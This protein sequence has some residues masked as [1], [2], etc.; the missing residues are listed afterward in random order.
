MNR[1]R[2]L[3]LQRVS[4]IGG[5]SA[6]ESIPQNTRF[7]KS[8]SGAFTTLTIEAALGA[9]MAKDDDA[10]NVRRQDAYIPSYGDPKRN[11]QEQLSR[12]MDEYVSSLEESQLTNAKSQLEGRRAAE[13]L[14]IK[15]FEEA[16]ANDPSAQYQLSRY[17]KKHSKSDYDVLDAKRCSGFLLYSYDK[18]GAHSVLGE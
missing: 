5:L 7:K 8:T 14:N 2:E 10:Y 9:Y 17:K 18:N 16:L 3:T 15:K 1:R 11:E 13:Q 6:V 12:Q 4:R